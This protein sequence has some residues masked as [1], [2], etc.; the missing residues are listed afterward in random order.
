MFFLEVENSFHGK[1]IQ[2]KC[3]EFPLSDKESGELHGM[4]LMNIKNAA[5]KYHGAVKWEVRGLVFVLS[6]M[7][8]NGK[9][10]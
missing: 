8:K 10:I 2:K 1:L 3:S 6:I 4:G 5:E 9:P 7:L